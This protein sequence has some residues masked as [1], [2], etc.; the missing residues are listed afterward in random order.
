MC[1]CSREMTSAGKGHGPGM[2]IARSFPA[3]RT[4]RWVW[5]PCGQCRDCSCNN[6]GRTWGTAI[7]VRAAQP[8]CIVPFCIAEAALPGLAPCSH[9]GSDGSDFTAGTHTHSRNAWG[10]ASWK[11]LC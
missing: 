10:E 5:S 2:E 6:L 4:Q 11:A 1:L 3:A 8:S 7:W 9:G